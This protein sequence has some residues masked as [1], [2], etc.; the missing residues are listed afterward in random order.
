MLAATLL[1]AS[2]TAPTPAGASEAGELQAAFISKVALFVKWPE[3]AF[4]SADA[5][6]R[7]G[8]LGADHHDDA[9]TRVLAEATTRGRS[10]EVQPVASVEEARQY[11]ILIVNETRSQDLR[12]IARDLSG[13]SV[14]SI[15]RS[16]PFAESGGIVGIEMY[17]GKVAF[18]VN[19]R[20]AQEANLKISSR[21]LRLATTVY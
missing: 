9:L 3:G 7:V 21:L 16:F 8:I 10:Y 14:L 5:P 19:N 20:A 18:E 15:A 1:L 11:H 13:A 4:A 6:I 17:R 12:K 2:V